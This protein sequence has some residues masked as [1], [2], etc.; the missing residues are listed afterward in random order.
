MVLVTL[1]FVVAAVMLRPDWHQVAAGALPSVPHH[2]AANYWFTV[3]SILGASIT[4]SLF[5]FY[6]SGAIE[7]H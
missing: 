2:D 1:S 3:V 5:L 6:S 4:P 7:D